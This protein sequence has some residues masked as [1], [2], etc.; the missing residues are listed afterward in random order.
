[1]YV[2]SFVLKFYHLKRSFIEFC[3]T[4]KLIL[5]GL[6]IAELLALPLT[7]GHVVPTSIMQAAQATGSTQCLSL[8]W[9]LKRK[10]TATTAALLSAAW[11]AKSR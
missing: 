2:S 3:N 11:L 6:R 4:E 9:M 1:M 10:K 7:T 8:C 5:S